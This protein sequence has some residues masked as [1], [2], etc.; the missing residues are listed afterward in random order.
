MKVV[1]FMK[2]KLPMAV[3]LV[4]P[5]VRMSTSEK[6]VVYPLSRAQLGP[7]ETQRI[8]L[9]RTLQDYLCLNLHT[10]FPVYSA[11][12]IVRSLASWTSSPSCVVVA[13]APTRHTHP[14]MASGLNDC[15]LPYVA[16]R[17][18]EVPRY[19]HGRTFTKKLPHVRLVREAQTLWS[20]RAL[21]GSPSCLML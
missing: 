20:G 10:S 21:S 11:Q 3:R 7:A 17:R 4:A 1:P 6:V 13:C 12:P 8:A 9:S 15:G 19:V 18:S 5:S 16:D 14:P 2:S